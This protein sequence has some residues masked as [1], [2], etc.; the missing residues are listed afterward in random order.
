M[1]VQ[2]VFSLPQQS[3]LCQVLEGLSWNLRFDRSK[4]QV[5]GNAKCLD[6]MWDFTGPGEAG[7]AKI[8]TWDVVLGKYDFQDRADRSL[9]CGIV[10]KKELECRIRT[11]LSDLV[12]YR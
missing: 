9:G 2:K 11:F 1:Q 12:V 5:W 4:E 3:D 6:M 8:L 10:V 7:F